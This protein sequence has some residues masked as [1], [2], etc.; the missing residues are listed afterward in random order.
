MN[1]YNAC[2]ILNLP[3]VFT[4]KELKQNYY[5]KA[6]QYHPDK[7]L[8]P[9]AKQKFQ[10]ILEAYNYLSKY[11][12][13]I[14]G[15][16]GLEGMEGVPPFKDNYINILEKFVNLMTGKTTDKDTFL[17]L[18]N[19]KYTEITIELLKQFPKNTLLKFHKFITQYKDILPNNNINR[20]LDDIIKE[21]TKDDTI[22]DLTPSLENLINNEIYKLLVKD[23][24]YYIPLWHH[25]LV[26]DISDNSLFVKCDPDLPEYITL[27]NYNNL[28][29]NIS[30][31][32]VSII[33]NDSLTINI[34]EKQYII[35]I[36]E[37][38]IKKYQRY[39][40]K[41][42]GIALIDTKNIYNIENRGN[43]CID[44]HF[45]DIGE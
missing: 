40:F 20:K 4:D 37:L 17:S 15:I 8:E 39:T 14:E 19:S 30:M 29:M 23:E 25:E 36:Q 33:N 31:T 43:I 42:E 35:P 12:E 3:N 26:Y 7:N 34:L 6:L 18:L 2:I 45:T 38:Y 21:Y 44:I 1:Y 32:L 5:M 27:D 28:Y 13:G 22:I 41:N 10:E 9:E 16:E 11:K 24:T